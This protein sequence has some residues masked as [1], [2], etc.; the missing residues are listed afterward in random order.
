MPKITTISP[1][2]SKPIVETEGVTYEQLEQTIVPKSVKAFQQWKK[3]SLEDRKAIVAKFS[4]LLTQESTVELLAKEITEQMGRPI[5]FTPVEIKTAALRVD[6][7]L[8]YADEAL[9]KVPVE[10]NDQFC[11]YL[12]RE[13]H[14]VVLIIFPWNYP[15]LTLVNGLIPALLAG[16]SVLIKPSPQ[17][18]KVADRVAELFTKAGLPD[19]VLQVVHSGEPEVIEKLVQNKNISA[20]AFTGSVAGGLAV[21]KAAGNRTIPIALELGGNDAAYVRG[22]VADIRATADDIV[23]GA[24]FNSG[25]SCCSI[26]RVYVHESI[27]DKFVQEATDIVKNYK[28]GDPFD[29]DTQVGP[30]I[31][32]AAA[33]RIRQQ[34][35][36]AKGS[37]KLIPEDHFGAAEK[38]NPT[39]V[40]PQILVDV[41]DTCEVVREETFGP[42]IPIIKVK[43]D[44]EAIE[45]INDSDYGLTAS[46]WTKDEQLG[47]QLGDEIEAG[48]VFVNRS[49]YPDPGLAWTGYKNSGRGVSL[50]KFGYEF[51]TKLKSHHIKHLK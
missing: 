21:Q 17:T 40:G 32:E 14:G 33:K 22:D 50:S 3:Q 37:R 30:V 13:P 7:M 11:K 46:V 43:S 20:V 42:I 12:S 35:A 41:D 45:K 10:N 44:Q 6:T 48:T 39:F 27:Y 51:Y 25:Q 16:N 18:P 26:E 9:A 2:T 23:D 5:R 28:V 36:E 49:D 8:G 31:S 1:I 4:E 15:Y 34:V 24:V 19:G 47:Q 29:P 38:L